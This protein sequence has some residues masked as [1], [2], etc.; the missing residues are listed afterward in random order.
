MFIVGVNVVLKLCCHFKE[1]LTELKKST[2]T[3]IGRHVTVN[4]HNFQ[5]RYWLGFSIYLNNSETQD[6]QLGTGNKGTRLFFSY[7][8]EPSFD[9][10]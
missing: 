3:M 6:K 4:I 1:N 10:I 9:V 5:R 7:I 8:I 2:E